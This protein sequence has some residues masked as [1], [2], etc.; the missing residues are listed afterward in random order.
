MGEME[1]ADC[2]GSANTVIFTGVKL[3]F[4]AACQRG[5]VAELFRFSDLLLTAI[6][7]LEIFSGTPRA[8]ERN[9]RI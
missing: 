5:V 9:L 4:Y 7:E 1:V 3:R 2:G 6:P 8:A